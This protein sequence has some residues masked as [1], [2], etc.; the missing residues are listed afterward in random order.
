MKG[1]PLTYNRDMQLDKEPLFNSCE[2][3]SLELRLFAGIIKTLKFNTAKIEAQ[4][5]DESLYA[6]DIVYYLVERGVA[7]KD[8][9]TIVGKLVRHS[10]ES[11]VAIKDMSENELKDFSSVITK[12]TLILLFHPGISVRAKRSIKRG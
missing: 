1:L 10:L 11:G 2:I 12:K 4:L 5:A 9:H 6:T 8:A 7:F 3:V